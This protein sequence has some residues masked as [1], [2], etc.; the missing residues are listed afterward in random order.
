M[1]TL[2]KA[3]ET[4]LAA[5][6]VRC[7]VPLWSGLYGV[8]FLCRVNV[9][10]SFVAEATRTC[11]VVNGDGKCLGRPSAFGLTRV[12]SSQ[13]RSCSEFCLK[14][15]RH[16]PIHLHSPNQLQL[17][18]IFATRASA[19]TG[20]PLRHEHGGENPVGC[21]TANTGAWRRG[22]RV[23]SSRKL[24]KT[25]FH[26]AL[27]ITTPRGPS[28][29]T[30]ISLAVTFTITLTLTFTSHSSTE[31]ASDWDWEWDWTAPSRCRS[32]AGQGTSTA[33]GT[34]AAGRGRHQ[35]RE[36]A[37]RRREAGRGQGR[38]RS[39]A[40]HAIRRHIHS[41]GPTESPPG[42]DHRQN[43]ERV[44]AHGMGSAEEVDQRPDQ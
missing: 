18:S 22:G 11:I 26:I 41:T 1:A 19:Q 38:V 39:T 40:R 21:A 13:L 37:H 6:Y 15:H 23:C 33:A 3:F 44:P 28:A 42:P 7:H 8:I 30:T 17:P 34:A 20:R 9:L 4:I 35:T 29:A 25:K 24:A 16:L 43:L 31:W 14:P 12:T 2:S 5:V 32:R 36:T 10:L 27:T